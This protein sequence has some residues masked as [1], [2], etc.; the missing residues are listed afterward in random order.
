M[1]EIINKIIIA[2]SSWLFR[3]L[4]PPFLLQGPSHWAKKMG[5]HSSEEAS[6]FACIYSV[7]PSGHNSNSKQTENELQLSSAE[8]DYNLAV[9]KQTTT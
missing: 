1:I 7:C 8:T 2:A 6:L 4:N 5:A 3:L 9:Q